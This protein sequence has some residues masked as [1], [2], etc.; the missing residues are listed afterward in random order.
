M[1]E[2][3]ILFKAEMVRAILSGKKTQTRRVVKP[4]APYVPSD[5][6]VDILV[7]T[8]QIRCPYGKPGDRLWVR[9]QFSGDYAC[10]GYPPREWPE[11]CPIWYWAD[12]QVEYGDWTKPKPSI[13]MPRKFSRIDLLIKDIRVER[14]QDITTE[15][16]IKEGIP[17]SEFL[18][19]WNARHYFRKLWDSINGKTYPWESNPWLWIVEFERR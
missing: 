18:D 5:S 2:R 11:D 19:R 10:D 4:P 9:E 13:H 6:G 15:D 8:D 16:V 7:A 17:D 12:G 3:P 1:K 14:L